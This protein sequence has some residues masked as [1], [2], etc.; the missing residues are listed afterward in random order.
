MAGEEVK[1]EDMV[2]D[3]GKVG[4]KT[5]ESEEKEMKEPVEEVG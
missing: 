2:M 3:I 5:K 1:E 4:Q